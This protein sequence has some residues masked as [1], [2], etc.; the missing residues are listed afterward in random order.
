MQ[1]HRN[2]AKYLLCLTFMYIHLISNIIQ[3]DS[4]NRPAEAN[5]CMFLVY[6]NSLFLSLFP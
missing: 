5:L 3:A 6:V 1:G 2:T 4:I